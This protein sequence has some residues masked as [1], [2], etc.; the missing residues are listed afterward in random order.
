M[1]I[2]A[3]GVAL[4]ESFVAGLNPEIKDSKFTAKIAIKDGKPFITWDPPLNGTESDGTCIKEG[5]RVYKV[6]GSNDLKNWTLV[7]NGDEPLYNF[8]KVSV[9][10]P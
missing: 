3:N 10:M 1:N 4:W 8:F 2:G 6:R 5:M 9:E 7:P